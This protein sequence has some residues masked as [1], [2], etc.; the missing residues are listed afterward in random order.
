M[1]NKAAKAV[2]SVKT[3]LEFPSDDEVKKA[4]KTFDKDGSGSL[5]KEELTQFAEAIVTASDTLIGASAIAGFAEDLFYCLD[6][7]CSGSISL[8]EFTASPDLLA[9]ILNLSVTSAVSDESGADTLFLR[10]RSDV[11]ARIA[12]LFYI[13]NWNEFCLWYTVSW[14]GGSAGFV[15]PLMSKEAGRSLIDNDAPSVGTGSLLIGS[16]HD[17]ESHFQLFTKWFQ[18]EEIDEWAMKII[19]KTDPTAVLK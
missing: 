5:D 15:D 3:L 17:Q 18:G 14:L 12:H 7:D 13:R 11:Q 10:P 6:T 4:W 1:G 19:N 8:E 9:I 16:V 2:K